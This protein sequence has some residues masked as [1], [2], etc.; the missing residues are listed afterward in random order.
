MKKREFIAH[1]SIFLVVFL[2]TV[3][4]VFAVEGTVPGT[5]VQ[6]Q[7]G[8]SILATGNSLEP[9]VSE[10]G[11]LTLSVDGLGMFPSSTGTIQV[12]K[13]A[14][15]TVK[16]AYLAAATTGFSGATLVNGDIEL[17]GTG[18][19]WSDTV[20]N[21]IGSN[22]YFADVTSIVKPVIDAAAAGI[23]DIDV[24]EVKPTF[25]VDGSI[26]AVIFDDPSQTHD[27][28]IVLFFGAQD[29]A[30][31]T[32]NI[33]LADPIDTGESGFALDMSLGIS[34]SFQ[35]AGQFS[36]IDVNGDRLTTSAGGQ[37]DGLPTDGALLTVGGIG[38][39]NSNPADPLATDSA[40]P[41]SDDEL[42]SLVPFVENGETSITVDTLNPSDDDNIFFSALFLGSTSAVVGEGIV[43]SPTE[44]VNPLGAEH[45]VTATVQDD[46][47]N[48]VE[49]VTVD[50]NIISGPN[51]G[52]FGSDVT[53]SDGKATFSYVGNT[54]GTDVIVA[55]FVNGEE[56][57]ITSNQATKEWV[58]ECTE[59]CEPP[60]SNDIPEFGTIG[61]A[62]ALSGIGAYLYR[63]R[64]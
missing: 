34:F 38:D 56:Q 48:P 40:G 41:R 50:F 46:E 64:K 47:G 35:P 63:K 2:M 61:A 42:Y 27:N 5:G 37:D 60:P 22:N 32:F 43:L 53:D 59:E 18:V 28:T 31:D 21:S 11:K 45:T 7:S 3:S 13:P 55:S 29:I 6:A 54:V 4:S 39:T 36:Q 52:G 9:V 19:T 24:E 14:G 58:E 57:E 12:E 26:L 62:F 33:G 49:G 15:A 30:G 1:I 10:T 51:N 17:E 25:D 8:F 16:A 23:V 20:A 44:A